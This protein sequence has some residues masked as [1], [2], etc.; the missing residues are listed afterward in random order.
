MEKIKGAFPVHKNIFKVGVK[1]L[2]ST[3]DDMLTPAG[4]ENFSPSF[5]NTIQDWYSMENEGWRSSLLTGKGWAIGFSGKRIVGDTANDYIAG[6]MLA[7]GQDACTKFSWELPDGLKIEQNVVISVTNNGDG[8]TINVGKL[9]FELRS[10][11]KPT[12]TEPSAAE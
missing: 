4:L 3:E 1:G 7:I 2:E 6:K 10:D 11:G 12:V 5:D 8:D 9:E